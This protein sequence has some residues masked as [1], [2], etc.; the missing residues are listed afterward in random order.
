MSTK[1]SE[2]QN[3]ILVISIIVLLLVGGLIVYTFRSI[4]FALGKSYEI[5]NVVGDTELRID[6]GSLDTAYKMITEKEVVKLEKGNQKF[7]FPQ[8][9][10]INE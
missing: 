7:I 5:D 3:N 9:T 4:F 2:K 10:N 1:V 8:A 6:R